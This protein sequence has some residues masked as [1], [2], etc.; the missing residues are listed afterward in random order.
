MILAV[1]TATRLISIA[2]HDGTRVVAE[3]TWHSQDNHTV[4]LAPAVRRMLDHSR[5]APDQLGGIG[6][7]IGPGS[8]TGLRIGLGLAKGLA[9]AHATP[10][11]GVPT[12]DVLAHAQPARPERMIA[13]LQAGRGRI[14]IAAYHYQDGGWQAEGEA[15]VSDWASLA[16]EATGP[17][18]FCGEIDPAGADALR[19]LKRLAIVPSPALALRRASHLAELAWAR[20]R[21]GRPDDPATLAPLYLKYPETATA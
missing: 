10:L 3:H 2:L 19:R 5:V 16:V 8:F 9:L 7:A 12:L 17:T 14:A 1:D 11:F 6:V 20:L 18:Y 15:Q 13:I 4:E 21:Q